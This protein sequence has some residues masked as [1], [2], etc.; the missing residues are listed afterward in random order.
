MTSADRFLA[1]GGGGA[2][3]GSDPLLE[4]F[5]LQQIGRTEPAIGYCGAASGDDPTKFEQ[6]AA[7]LA[8]AG[9]RAS[10]IAMTATADAVTRWAAPLDAIYFGGG[11]SG[12]LIEHLKSSGWA[13]VIRQAALGGKLLAGVSAGANCWF[14][15]SLSDAGG[16]GLRPLEGLGL[17]PGSICPHYSS[18]PERRH[19]F[20]DLIARGLLVDGTAIDDGVAVLF[21]ADAPPVAFSAR[22]GNW[23]YA[24]SKD[25]A[26]GVVER[27]LA[28]FDEP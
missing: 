17:I 26:G 5:L 20:P 3:N 25:E 24:V 10:Q 9:A 1:F 11:H 19:V 22:A 13:D 18:E 6:L 21:R 15:W 8:Q 27:P 23:A 28:A 12:R 4:D 7:R 14:D 2:T 16:N